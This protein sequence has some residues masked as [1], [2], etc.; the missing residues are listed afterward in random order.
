MRV[1]SWCKLVH[2]T[3]QSDVKRLNIYLE[4]PGCYLTNSIITNE[5][6]L[7]HFACLIISVDDTLSIFKLH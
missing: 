3:Y 5:H 7:Q 1:K 2:D 6:V 4:S